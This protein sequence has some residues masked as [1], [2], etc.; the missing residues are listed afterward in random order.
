M[1]VR[2]VQVYIR[3]RK[4]RLTP[5]ATCGTSGDFCAILCIIVDFPSDVVVDD[6]DDDAFVVGGVETG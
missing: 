3:W 2:T 1:A 6:D 5:E 4:S